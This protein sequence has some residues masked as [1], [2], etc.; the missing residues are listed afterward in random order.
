LEKISRKDFLKLIAAGGLGVA[1]T[2]SGFDKFSGNRSKSREASAQTGGSW[3]FGPDATTIPVHAALLPSGKIFYLSGSGYHNPNRWGPYEARILDIETGTEKNFTTEKDLFCNGMAHLPNGNVVL[4]GGTELYA[5]DPSSCNGQW[6]GLNTNVI[7]DWQSE[8]L[9]EAAPMLHGRWYPTCVTMHDGRILTINGFDE[10]GSANRLL[11][12]YD[13]SSDTW[14]I[15]YDPGSSVT[16]CVGFNAVDTCEGAGSPCYGGPSM[17]VA[18]NIG[19]YPRMHLLPNGKISTCGMHDT[20]RMYDPSTQR[21]TTFPNKMSTYRHYGPTFLLPFDNDEA[22]KGKILVAGGSPNST[23]VSTNG[24]EIIDYDASSTDSPVI[25]TVAPMEYGRKFA[26]VS[27]LPDGKCAIFGGTRQGTT[28]YIYVPEVFDP[29]TESWQSLPPASVPRGYH[30]EGI[31]L[32][33]GRVWTAGNT[34][35][36]SVFEL[37]TEIFSPWYMFEPRP[38]ITSVQN[39]GD[40]GGTIKINSPDAAKIEHISL[41]RLQSTTHHYDANLRCVWLQKESRTSNTLFVRAPLNNN[42]APPGYYLIHVIDEEGV[43]SAGKIIK[44]PGGFVDSTMPAIRI[45]SPSAGQ[46]IYGSS[47]GV[48][49]SIVGA[50]VDNGTGIHKV[51]LKIGSS[52]SYSEA[53]PDASNDWSLWRYTTTVTESGSVVINVR[54]TD[55]SGNSTTASIPVNITFI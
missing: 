41:I 30:T 47:S 3:S 28:E 25:R 55:N 11:E 44:I 50:A 51:E 33:D 34:P 17:G 5:N 36:T 27:I 39:V 15:S 49:I 24:A 8:T 37:R 19:L 42:I 46:T 52:S 22:V 29:S 26:M 1:I 2:I 23:S 13:P 9:V 12:I 48:D 7:V 38:T 31:L 4:V 18:P 40:Y 45:I 43:P 20:I 54:A 16:Y 6:H 10:Y 32:P 14:S 35:T 21:W 53:M